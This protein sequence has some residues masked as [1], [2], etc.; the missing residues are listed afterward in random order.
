LEFDQ[1]EQS[2]FLPF[3]YQT[4]QLRSVAEKDR[5]GFTRAATTDL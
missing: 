2:P 4:K 3:R 5:E 1:L